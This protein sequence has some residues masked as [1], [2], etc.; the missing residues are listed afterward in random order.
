M[1]C[2]EEKSVIVGTADGEFLEIL[3]TTCSGG[4]AFHG[5]NTLRRRIREAEAR[6]ETRSQ[7]EKPMTS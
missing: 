4:K 1:G 3:N 5:N 6:A 2:G 7:Y